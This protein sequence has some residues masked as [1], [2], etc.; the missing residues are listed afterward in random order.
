MLI[1]LPTLRDG[2]NGDENS[3]KEAALQR[4][5]VTHQFFRLLPF[6][7]PRLSDTARAS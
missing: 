3:I 7:I 5:P 1:G 6:I 2:G 4:L